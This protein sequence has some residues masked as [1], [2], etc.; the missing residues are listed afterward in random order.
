[1]TAALAAQPNDC[2]GISVLACS[3]V[4]SCTVSGRT[5]WRLSCI[6]SRALMQRS[7]TNKTVV[8]Q[9]SRIRVNMMASV[10]RCAAG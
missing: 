8:Q 6:I 7:R 4:K 5:R 9:V 10:S 2:D 3:M 1:M